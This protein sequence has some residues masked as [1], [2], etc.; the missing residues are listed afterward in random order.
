MHLWRVYARFFVHAAIP[1]HQ[2]LGGDLGNFRL[3]PKSGVY[4]GYLAAVRVNFFP[5]SR[6]FASP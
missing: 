1:Y 6:P 2:L 3:D 4:L 5:S